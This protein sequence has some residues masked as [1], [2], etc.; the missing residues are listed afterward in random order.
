MV[1]LRS[2]ERVVLTLILV[3]MTSFA[4][5]QDGNE[6][7]SSQRYPYVIGASVSM[8]FNL[9]GKGHSPSLYAL[10]KMGYERDYIVKKTVITGTFKRKM[11]WLEDSLAEKPPEVIFGIDL[12]HHNTEDRPEVPQST[13]D[14]VDEILELLCESGVPVIVGDVWTRRGDDRYARQV[15]DYLYQQAS[16]RDNLFIFPAYDLMVA[17]KGEASPFM[18]AIDG[19]ALAIDER[20][21]KK[22]L[23]DIVHPN[24]DGAKVMANIIINLMNTNTD[25]E[26]NYYDVSYVVDELDQIEIEYPE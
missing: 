1:F 26:I 16:E 12:F 7:E 20:R 14:Y 5:A 8:G 19:E 18:Y 2:L 17:I 6:L 15:S 10:E 13:Y 4:C 22:L 24:A 21:G 25:S 9:F 3:S 23:L 11:G